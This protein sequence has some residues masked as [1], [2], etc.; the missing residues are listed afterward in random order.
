[1]FN[2]SLSISSDLSE[3]NEKISKILSEIMSLKNLQ[4]NLILPSKKFR[5]IG[6]IVRDIVLSLCSSAL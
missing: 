3:V 2:N 5:S 4:E 6:V 1:M